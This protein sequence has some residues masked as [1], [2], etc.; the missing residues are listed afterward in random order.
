[1]TEM[2]P[3]EGITPDTLW[4]FLVVLVG[5]CGLFVLYDKVGQAVENVKKRK[6][7]PAE[8]QTSRMAEEISQKVT[9]TISGQLDDIREKLA[10][11]KQRLDAQE[12]RLNVLEAAQVDVS[13][14]LRVMCTG[15][16]AVLN[17]ELH[18]GNSDEMMSALDGLNKY[19]ITQIGRTK[20]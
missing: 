14:G 9:E 13:E 3:I 10:T 11:D 2:Q 12:R 4:I 5:L 20:Q 17:H 15:M 1:M 6:H 7:K 18:N 8:A 16:T 19:L